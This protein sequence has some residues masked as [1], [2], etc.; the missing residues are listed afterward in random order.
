MKSLSR[1]AAALALY[2]A[3]AA[4]ALR[5]LWPVWDTHIPGGSQDTRLFL[6]NAW[7][8]RYA[9]DVLHTSPFF[10]PHLFHPFG[11]SLVTHD[12]PVWNG[13]ITY[14]L[15]KAVSFLPAVNLTFALTWVL[16]GFCTYLLARQ[17]SGEE[18]PARVAG[19]YVMTH[20][21]TL[22]RG[23]QNWGQFNLFGIPLFFWLLV[24][25]RRSGLLRD[26]VWAGFALAFTAACHYYYLVFCALVWLAVV[27]LDTQPWRVSAEPR[28]R[29]RHSGF[30]FAAVPFACVAA[31]IVAAEPGRLDWHGVRI[32]LTSPAN[33]LLAMWLLLLAWVASGWRV[34]W[35]KA[36]F[37]VDRASGRRLHAALA[38]AALGGLVPLLIGAAKTF[39]AGDY[40][41][42][43]ILWKTHPLGANLL[44]FVMP[45]AVHASWGPA[46][47]RWFTDRGLEPQDQA[48]G[49]GWTFLAVVLL[50]GVRRDRGT[51]R[52]WLWLGG[53]FSLM[54]MGAY[55]HVAQWNTWLPLPFFF[56]KLLPI[57]GNARIP[58]RWMAVAAVAF[59]VVLALG[60]VRLARER[61]WTLNRWCLLA[62]A[63][64]LFENW[65]GW[66]IRE[67][68]GDTAVYAALRQ[69][70][71][72]GVLALPFYAGDS[73]IGAGNA[74]GGEF[75]FPW[76]QLWAQTF[77]ETP[78]TGGYIGRIPRRLIRAYQADPFFATLIRLEE[79]TLKQTP[80][81]PPDQACITAR[82]FR[83]DHL[84][85]FR[86]QTPPAALA[87]TLASFPWTKT[88]ETGQIL[89]YQLQAER[90]PQTCR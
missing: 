44:S 59:A 71:S 8:V 1:S 9:L 5:K 80:P 36:D 41:S 18:A 58:E 79:G 4:I 40:P 19:L 32:S 27:A 15:G 67:L 22:A 14:A 6:W 3:V 62:G 73:S 26:A 28:S 87:F 20:S 21:Y 64:I 82:E 10:T 72:S 55:L 46:V 85:L 89:L 34:I 75:P 57:I 29:G 65:P 77:H 68:P 31:W 69:T 35:R 25:A 7:W 60:L 51:A 56:A 45:N 16:G 74:L 37:S 88:G 30:F 61:R 84:L 52:R 33:A 76:H 12:F 49:L 63:L 81:L 66:A 23:V 42:Q 86:D 38:G 50:S 90:L 53:G 83:F 2:A 24:R 43:S 13:G 17:V 78:I 47:S 48:A 54:A 70:R 11:V 39:I